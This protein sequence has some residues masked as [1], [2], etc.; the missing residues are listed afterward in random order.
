RAFFAVTEPE[1]GS[2]ATAVRSRLY[3]A[4]G[5]MCLS[6]IKM[7]IGGVQSA[8][9]GL[10]FAR[11]ERSKELCLVMIEPG[12]WPDRVICEDLPAF[13]LAGARLSR[14]VIR[15]FPIS[16]DDGI[17]GDRR[18]LRD[19]LHGSQHAFERHRP[20]VGAMAVGAAQGMLD[21]LDRAG[22]T[23]EALTMYKL[24]HAALYRLMNRVASSYEQ[25]QL[26]GHQASLF[27][28]QATRFAE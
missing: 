14:L 8:S 6:A 4:H 27:K 1:V 25:G 17:G 11:R 18:S 26:R 21:A 19:W 3:D 13:G 2:D 20:M 16:A 9:V 28:F 24:E 7:L 23:A 15:D 22:V 5:E 10:I 12:R